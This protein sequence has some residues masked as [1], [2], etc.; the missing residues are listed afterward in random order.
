[1]KRIFF[2]FL[3]FSTTMIAYP[4]LAYPPTRTVD[5]SDTY[6]GKTIKDPYRWLEN[7][8][9]KEVEDWFKAQALLSDSLL[10]RIP[11]RD[12]L[13]KEWMDVA[14]LAQT[15]KLFRDRLRGKQAL[16]QEDQGRRKHR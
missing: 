4:Q 13:V 2:G 11:G 14:G 3:F 10:N 12:S 7:I 8:K 1:M 9:S 16:L 6:W 15:R 5:S